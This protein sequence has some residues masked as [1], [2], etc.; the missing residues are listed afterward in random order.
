MTGSP[1]VAISGKS[2]GFFESLREALAAAGREEHPESTADMTPTVRIATPARSVGAGPAAPAMLS[3]AEAARIARTPP[4]TD[5]DHQRDADTPPTTRVVRGPLIAT[6]APAQ[7]TTLLRGKQNVSRDRFHDDPV[8]GWLVVVGGPGL[9]SYRPIHEGNN[10]MG[11]ASSQRIPI[12]FG[13]DSISAEEQAFIRYDSIDRSFLFVPN[14]AKTNVVR[15][16]DLKPTS[17]LPLAAMDVITMGR[18]Q[19]VFVPFCGPQFDWSALTEAK[20]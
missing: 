3:A 16:N 5:A 12:D 17:A 11:R 4:A 19:M 8:V 9:G 20:A 14:L 10:T 18:T 7:R 13:D 1:D 2:G 6:Q 15:V